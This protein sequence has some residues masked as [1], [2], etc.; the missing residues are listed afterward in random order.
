M[1]KIGIAPIV[2]NQKKEELIGSISATYRFKGDEQSSGGSV[3]SVICING[4]DQRLCP[5]QQ[6]VCFGSQETCISNNWLGCTSV[7]YGPDYENGIETRYDGKDNNCN[8]VP[9]EGLTP[10]TTNPLVTINLP[11]DPIYYVNNLKIHSLYHNNKL[12]L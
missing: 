12:S 3:P 4:I 11:I 1:K 7:N 6:G 2:L 9:D 8:G 10:D 5:L